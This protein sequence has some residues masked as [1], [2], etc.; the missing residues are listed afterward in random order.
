M[1]AVP[2]KGNLIAVKKSLDLSRVGYEL[3]DRKRNILIREMMSYIDA[4]A[5]LQDKVDSTYAAAYAAL[6]RA[7]TTMGNCADVASTMPVDDSLSISFRSV[8][9]VELPTVTVTE[10]PAVRAMPFGL[11]SSCSMLDEAYMR[12]MEVKR[13][14]AKL[15]EVENCVYRLADAIKKTQK[16]A[17]ALKNILIPRFEEEVRFITDALDEKERE[18]F[19]RLKVIKSMKDDQ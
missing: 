3:L 5:E 17:N 16:R 2:T 9:G 12:F 8:M 4:A 1:A 10:E 19:A 14:T 11:A 13:L 18:E 15:S 7:N 6:M